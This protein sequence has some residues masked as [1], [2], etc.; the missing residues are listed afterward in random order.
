MS[1]DPTIMKFRL[2]ILISLI[3]ILSITGLYA[4]ALTFDVIS[5]GEI[6]DDATR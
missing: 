3:S 6:E 1:G 4:Y 2:F 5:V